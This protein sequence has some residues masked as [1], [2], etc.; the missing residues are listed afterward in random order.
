MSNLTE[1][2]RKELELNGAFDSEIYGG[3]IG[4][5]VMA[6]IKLFAEQGHSGM[7][8][9]VVR[10]LFNT[11]AGYELLNPLTGEDDEWTFIGRDKFTAFPV[12]VPD[13][14]GQEIIDSINDKKPEMLWQ[15][16]RCSHVFKG[17]DGRSYDSHGKVFRQPDGGCYTNGNSRVYVEFPYTPKV[18]YVNVSE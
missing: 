1:F 2:A 10:G 9:S 16:K 8:A 5:A 17:P 4:E 3:M 11:L 14:V 13:E 18:E 6:L 15:N 7:S 12:S